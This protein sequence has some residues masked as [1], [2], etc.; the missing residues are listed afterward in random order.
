MSPSSGERLAQASPRGDRGAGTPRSPGFMSKLDQKQAV[1]LPLPTDGSFDEYSAAPLRPGQL[2]I[3]LWKSPAD[4]E[5]S[6]GLVL[7]YPADASI[8]G[9]V[10]SE[11]DPEG[12]VSVKGFT[13]EPGDFIH[14]VDG[15]PITILAQAHERLG[16]SYAKIIVSKAGPL[17]QGWVMK[18]DKKSDYRPYYVYARALLATYSHPN[19]RLAHHQKGGGADE[20][21]PAAADVSPASPN[22]KGMPALRVEA[23]NPAEKPL[24]TV[25]TRLPSVILT[26]PFHDD[27][28]RLNLRHALPMANVYVCSPEQLRGAFD[29]LLVRAGLLLTATAN[30]DIIECFL[31]Q[32]ALA[33]PAP[34]PLSS[35]VMEVLAPPK[36]QQLT[37][38]IAKSAK[39]SSWGMTLT[40]PADASNGVVISELDPTGLAAAS[41]SILPG[42]RID[43][44]DGTQISSRAEAIEQLRAGEAHDVVLTITRTRGL[45]DG[46]MQRRDK[47]SGRPYF[48]HART[49][50]ATFAHPSGRA[51]WIEM[52]AAREEN[53]Q[54]PTEVEQMDPDWL[55]A[56]RRPKESKGEAPYAHR[57]PLSPGGTDDAPLEVDEGVDEKTKAAHWKKVR[58]QQLRE[59]EADGVDMT[60]A[61]A[62][63]AGGKGRVLGRKASTEL[64][65]C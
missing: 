34:P 51:A 13:L 42:D 5:R 2:E 55:S 63:G 35:R 4:A 33:P 49:H 59:D 61:D 36:D 16:G 45:P 3:E 40:R 30:Q 18:K 52:Q 8:Q 39:K 19:G 24:N 44:I 53:A 20:H 21:A 31:Q 15:I 11:L 1:A 46:W 48:I 6:W 10:I 60:S 47:S 25:L 54:D 28:L 27:F 56:V 41:N 26:E 32:H 22:H 50:T 17:P 29:Q 57:Y 7:C 38:R 14:A 62:T 9:V 64:I 37:I 65:S 43:A 12:L 23:T 58:Q